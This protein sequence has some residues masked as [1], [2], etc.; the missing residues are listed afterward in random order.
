MTVLPTDQMLLLLRSCDLGVVAIRLGAQ[1]GTTK[2]CIASEVIFLLLCSIISRCVYVPC[3]LVLVK[4]GLQES[5]DQ[6]L[7]SWNGV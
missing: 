3:S 1:E 5:Y 4:L 2:K 6:I 7:H